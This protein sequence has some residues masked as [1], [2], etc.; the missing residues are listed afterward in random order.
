VKIMKWLLWVVLALV[1]VLVIGGYVLS[2]RFTVSRSVVIQ[3]PPDKVYPFVASP[4]QW[5]RWSVWN[6]RDPAMRIDYAGPDSGSGAQW[7]W[8]SKSQGDG[9]MTFTAAEPPRRVAYA[10]F[11]KDFDTTSTGDVRLADAGAGATRVTWTMN[12]DMGANPV[13]HWMALFADGMVGKDFEGGLANL[14]EV[15][16]KS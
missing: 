10:L 7:A 12:G 13:F 1:A 9:S 14:K 8:H 15:V 16:E 6:R 5:T 3:A 2:S 11:F 4:R